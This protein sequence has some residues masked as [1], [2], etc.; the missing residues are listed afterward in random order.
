MYKA[1]TNRLDKLAS[2]LEAKGLIK[3]ATD[4][5]VVSNTLEKLAFEMAATPIYKRISEAM[6]V[7]KSGMGSERAKNILTMIAGQDLNSG[8]IEN[9]QNQYSGVR[10]MQ[11]FKRAFDRAAQ[12]LNTGNDQQAY[13]DL[14]AAIK[15]LE[16]A[17][18]K[19]KQHNI[20][21]YPGQTDQ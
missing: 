14:G 20:L 16:A 5:D 8:A 13:A 6:K 15:T 2:D 10:E 3:E 17:E 21:G 11:L 18:P 12:S 19:I 9:F 4:I 7:L 1:L